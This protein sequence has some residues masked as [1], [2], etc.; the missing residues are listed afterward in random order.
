[1][2]W[3]S[4]VLA[5]KCIDCDFLTETPFGKR[6]VR[7]TEHCPKGTS[8]IK[9]KQKPKPTL[10]QMTEHF[11]K[12]MAKWGKSGFKTVSKEEYIRRRKICSDCS[13]GWRCPKCGCMLWAKVALETQ[14]CEKWND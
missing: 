6:C 5:D 12:S 13:G 1:M 4:E 3:S 9:Q 11:A 2:A 7:D 10:P 14:E 8:K